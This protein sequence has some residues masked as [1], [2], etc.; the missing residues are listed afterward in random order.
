MATILF[1]CKF[2]FHICQ[3]QFEL[4]SQP[5]GIFHYVMSRQV[6]FIYVLALNQSLL[7]LKRISILCASL[8]TNHDQNF[9]TSPSAHH[10]TFS[11]HRFTP[12]STFGR[13]T[14]PIAISGRVNAFLCHYLGPARCKVFTRHLSP[15]HT[16]VSGK[17]L[18]QL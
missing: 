7:F 6:M 14:S 17:E 5:F 10:A 16:R 8:L 15:L 12:A 4:V 9:R 13:A 11:R 1:S 2:S 18:L 3:N